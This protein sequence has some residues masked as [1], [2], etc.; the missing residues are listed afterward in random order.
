MPTGVTAP[1]PDRRTSLLLD[2]DEPA[3]VRPEILEQRSA[4]QISRSVTRRAASSNVTLQPGGVWT[5]FPHAADRVIT[6]ALSTSVLTAADVNLATSY[7]GGIDT[8]KKPTET[9]MGASASLISSGAPAFTKRVASGGTWNNEL[10]ADVTAFPKPVALTEDVPL[11]RVLCSKKSYPANA[12]FEVGFAVPVGYTGTDTLMRFYFGGPADTT[13][14]AGGAFAITLR[15]DGRAFLE[16]YNG[17]TWDMRLQFQWA[18]GGRRGNLEL[19]RLRVVPIGRDRLAIYT[20]AVDG[21][22]PEGRGF[23]A[24]ALLA[25]VA[26]M[27]IALQGQQG[28]A[29]AYRAVPTQTGYIPGP[30]LTGAGPVR[31]DIRRDLRPLTQI[32]HLQYPSSGTLVDLPFN[33]PYPV[34]AST[35]LYLNVNGYAPAGSSITVAAYNA[36]DDSL[37]T[38][39]SSLIPTSDA[40]FLTVA[41]QQAYYLRFTFNRSSAATNQTPALFGVDFG[42]YCAAAGV[43]NR[44]GE[45]QTGGNLKGVHISGPDLDP[46]HETHSIQLEDPTNALTLLKT[47]GDIHAQVLIKNDAGV[48]QTILAE[49]II[50]RATATRK[51]RPGRTYPNAK[52]DSFEIDMGGM[53]T[54]L[55]THL[56]KAPRKFVEDP[57]APIDPQTGNRFPWKVTDA[58]RKVLQL[59]AGIPADQL[60][61]PDIDIRFGV[62]PGQ[63][64]GASEFLAQPAQS[65]AE[66]VQKWVREYIGAVLCWDPNAGSRGMWRL[67]ANPVAPYT[68]LATFRGKPAASG[69]LV[70]HLG[71]YGANGAFIMDK[72]RTW[73]QAPEANFIRVVGIADNGGGSRVEQW[74]FNPLSFDL[75]SVATSDPNH[76]DY[77]G[78]MKPLIVIDYGLIGQTAVNFACRRFYE[79][80]AIARKWIAFRAPLLLVTNG[81]DVSQTRARPLRINDAITVVLDSVSYTVLLRS[82]NVDYTHDKCQMCEYEGVFVSSDSLP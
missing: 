5:L 30:Y 16:E 56:I 70:T 7:T 73:V 52:Y 40:K 68:S 45:N 61:I 81:A 51:G 3:V 6:S 71:S 65:V 20:S 69:K 1:T 60:D 44:T 54:R 53:W 15:G 23:S 9:G 48:L 78:H 79:Q 26:G 14:R 36:A 77:I 64:S 80:L 34:P 72:W 35:L 19:F 41:G 27:S 25:V 4:V 2:P 21:F 24:G 38:P 29:T 66:L 18:M 55:A 17:S 12:G 43:A 74:M 13:G 50:H 62:P 75:L 39:S 33:L 22:V 37:L 76:P 46:T 8:Y 31:L 42:C 11:D 32:V 67:L 49:G 63:S 28:G 82:V 57:A 58:I 59:D 10:T 47:R